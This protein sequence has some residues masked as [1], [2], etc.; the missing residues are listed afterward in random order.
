MAE[1]KL[2]FI[3]HLEELRKRLIIC[4]VAIAVGFGICCFF[5]QQLVNILTKPLKDALPLGTHLI[6]TGVSEAFFSYLKVS[7]F[8]GII[9]ATPVI[10]YEIWCFVSP[11]LYDKEKKY[12]LPFVFFSTILF[13]SGV[14]F[15]YYI[16]LP[17]TYKFFMSYTTDSIKPFPSLREYLSF[18]SKMLLAFGITFELPIFIL[19]LSKIGLVNLKTLTAYRKYAI[20]L[21]FIVAAVV[22]PSTDVVSQVLTALPLWILYEIS[23]VLVRIFNRKKD[24]LQDV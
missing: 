19:F 5:D 18:S 16:V 22:T 13:V 10:L 1:E 21:I 15:S 7:F 3:S 17:I 14:I 6:F 11:G 23:I 24:S 12:V 20:L 4:I 9:L 8:A 2:S